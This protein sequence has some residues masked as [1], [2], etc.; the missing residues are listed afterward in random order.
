MTALALPLRSLEDGNRQPWPRYRPGDLVTPV[1]GYPILYEVLMVER[2]G[3]LRV[4]GMNW[5]PGYSA[6]VGTGEVRSVT[7]I[8]LD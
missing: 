2:E 6:L 4:R 3:T 5:A 1:T 7:R 8:L